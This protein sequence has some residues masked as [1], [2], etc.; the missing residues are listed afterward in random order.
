MSNEVAAVAVDVSVAALPAPRAV[1]SR[2]ATVALS[3][4]ISIVTFVAFDVLLSQV[5]W[6]GLVRDPD[7]RVAHPVHHHDLRP[8][9][10][11]WD[12]WGPM[13]YRVCTN[14]LG[15]K[16]AS[17]RAVPPV[18]ALPRT[19][20]IGD[21]FT[22]AVGM[23]W[24]QSFAGLYAA[25]HPEVEVLNAGVSSYAPAVYYAKVR[26]LLEQGIKLDRVVVF[27]DISDIQDE[28]WY[29]VDQAGVVT[30]LR[31][32]ADNAFERAVTPF[33]KANLKGIVNIKEF[34][35]HLLAEPKVVDPFT[36]ARGSW[37]FADWTKLA[38]DYAP[39]GVS[40]AITLARTDMDRLHALLAERK[41][42][43]TVAVYPWP[44]QMKHDRVDGLQVRVWKD[45]CAGKCDRF[46][47][48]FPAFFAWRDA[49]PES[50]Y[51]DLY[52]AGDVHF[53]AR[54]NQLVAAVLEEGL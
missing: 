7:L 17:A 16:D 53:N 29:R 38:P 10:C 14:A 21:S 8:N 45:W 48:A 50:W 40:G 36:S 11:T 39:L 6:F 54:G 33:T 2:A 3:L 12:E 1:P 44:A 13:R 30:D 34:L 26:G 28:T 25:R 35:E 19:L 4:L 46:V 42:P 51:E 49:H 18:G 52:V 31:P 5:S 47:D 20:F 27:M 9:L 37:T 32:P 15:F 23:P 22:E 43:L 41:I 24:Q